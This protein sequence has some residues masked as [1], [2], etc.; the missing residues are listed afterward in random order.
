MALSDDIKVLRDRVQADLIVAHDYFAESQRLWF[1][2]Q[3]LV[4]GGTA[5]IVHNSATGT[6]TTQSELA[7]KAPGYVSE[8]LAEATFQ[9]FISL[10]E[11][12]F[13]DLLRLWLTAFP[14]S[15]GK[16]MVEFRAILD[17]P[18]KDAI[19]QLVIGKELNEVLYERPSEWFAYLEERAKLGGQWNDE[20]EQIAEAKAS[21][22]VLVHNRKVANKIYEVKS[23]RLARFKDGELLDIPE[24]Y[25]RETWEMLRRVVADVCNAAIAKSS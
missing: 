15:L 10:F 3:D 17:L 5:F 13:F 20:I 21:R 4:V 1:L 19:A 12:F 7:A 14:K 23:G 22:D 24:Q 8:Q 9:Q 6:V 16:K 2:V 18:D 11:N 25:H